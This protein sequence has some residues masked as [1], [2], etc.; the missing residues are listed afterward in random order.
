[1]QALRLGHTGFEQ[2][3]L[4]SVGVEGAA[5]LFRRPFPF[6]WKQQGISQ[7]NNTALLLAA[8]SGH[9]AKQQHPGSLFSTETSL[10]AVWRK[11]P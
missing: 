5:F 8:S 3:R 7:P 6:E 4:R 2:S 9:H 10:L 1:M 11:F